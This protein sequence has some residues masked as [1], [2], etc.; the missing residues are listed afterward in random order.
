M[1]RQGDMKMERVLRLAQSRPADLLWYPAIGSRRPVID[2]VQ[3]L[4]HPIPL[5]GVQSPPVDRVDEIVEEVVVASLM[6]GDPN[7]GGRAGI[8][9]VAK[10]FLA[11]HGASTGCK[12]R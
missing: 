4:D 3:H 6:A 7:P 2:L 11:Q 10:E 12:G 5:V 9:S 1:C 8:I